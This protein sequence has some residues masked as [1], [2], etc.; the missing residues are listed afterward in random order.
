MCDGSL[1]KRSSSLFISHSLGA[2]GLTREAVG[3]G[4]RHFYTSQARDW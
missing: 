4:K 2:L 1:T 3:G